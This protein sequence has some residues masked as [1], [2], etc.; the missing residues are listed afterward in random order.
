[1]KNYYSILGI[2]FDSDVMTIKKTYRQL[3]LKY[4]PDKNKSIDAHDKFIE[5]TEAY[6]ILRNESTKKEYDLLF[7]KFFV[8]NEELS[9]ENTVYYKKWEEE[10]S[11]K[12]EEYAKKMY[13]EFTDILNEITFHASNY[14]KIG[15]VGGVYIFLGLIWL[16]GPI[17]MLLTVNSGDI[18]GPAILSVIMGIGALFIGNKKI[19]EL[20]EDY[21]FKKTNFKHK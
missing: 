8:Q 2:S 13:N 5:I 20:K 1:M 18:V 15:C 14:A 4:H 19:K 16:I 21:Q 9:R 6:E 11:K 17:I 3:A 10:G 7:Y 12:G